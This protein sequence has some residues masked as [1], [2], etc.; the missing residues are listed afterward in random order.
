[1]IGSRE[2]S[3]QNINEYLFNALQHAGSTL[4]FRELPYPSEWNP[5]DRPHVAL[6]LCEKGHVFR[7][8][9][10]TPCAEGKRLY[11]WNPQRLSIDSLVEVKYNDMDLRYYRREEKMWALVGEARNPVYKEFNEF[12]ILLRLEDQE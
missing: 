1:M 8:Y 5:I 4:H 12:G 7:F 6:L 2:V 9:L 3:H 11:V 10:S